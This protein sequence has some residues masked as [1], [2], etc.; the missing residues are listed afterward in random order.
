MYQI[1]FCF[2]FHVAFSAAVTNLFVVDVSSISSAFNTTVPVCPF[3]EIT[4]HDV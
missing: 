4:S 2:A 1:A 3:T